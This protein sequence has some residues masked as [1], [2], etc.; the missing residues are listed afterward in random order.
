M[1]RRNREI[2]R[3]VIEDG[4]TTIAVGEMFGISR[5]RVYQIL[6]NQGITRVPDR[7]SHQKKQ[8]FDFI[9]EYKYTH[10]GVSPS[11]AE[12][13]EGCSRIK[14]AGALSGLAR[15][16][17]NDGLIKHNLEEADNN[18][19]YRTIQVVGGNWYLL[20]R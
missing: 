15:S 5:Q 9:V 20:R 6:R 10:D 13:V 14:G 19:I 1:T 12:I 4:L 8:M 16:L 2:K 7:A 18:R 3:L 17:A 11:G